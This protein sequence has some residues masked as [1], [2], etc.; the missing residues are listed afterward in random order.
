MHQSKKKELL[1]RRI[2]IGTRKPFKVRIF[3][4]D[5]E[6]AKVGGK[7]EV[8]YVTHD[9]SI[10]PNERIKRVKRVTLEQNEPKPLDSRTE[11][12]K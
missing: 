12:R 9:K 3:P 11:E 4:Q 7:V 5:Y 2:R 6:K 8:E 10:D 1:T